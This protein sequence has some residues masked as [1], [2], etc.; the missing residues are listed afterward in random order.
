[1]AK[2]NLSPAIN[3][4]YWCYPSC[5]WLKYPLQLPLLVLSR[6]YLGKISSSISFIGVIPVV[7]G[8]NILFNILYW[9]YPGCI[10]PKYP[11]QYPLLVLSRLYLGK[12]SSSISFIGVIPVVFGQNIL[13][14][15]LYWCYPGCIWPKYPLQYPLLVLSR[16]YL[17]K[18]SSSISF[19]GVIPVVFGQN[20]LFNILYWCYPGCIWPKYSL[21][22][23]LLVLS[24]LYLGK[25]SPLSSPFYPLLY[26]VFTVT[27][28]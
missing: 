27:L 7:F 28:R 21:Q 11:L 5:I 16:L 20:I 15:I 13:F 24:R 8:Q 2:I 9:C 14:N 18:I 3:I 6:L 10:W 12:I 25:I 1:M 26:R 22:Y 4:L 23:P 19:I 17:A